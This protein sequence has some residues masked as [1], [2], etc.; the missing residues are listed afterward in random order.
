MIVLID[1]D[2]LAYRISFACKDE[3]VAVAKNT[4]N[5]A[6]TDILMCGVDNTFPN[7]Y[8]D[9]WK[10]YLTGK[11]NFRIDV[12]KTAVYKGN[13]TAPKPEHLAPLREHLVKEWGAGVYDGQE[14]DDAIAIDATHL[15]DNCIVSSVD[16]DLD[17]IPGWHYNFVKK[18]GYYISPEQSV[19][20]LYR[21]ILTGDV[22]DN[23][24]GLKGIG[25]VKAEK[26]L[27]DNNKTER[28]YYDICVEAYGGDEDRVIENARLLFLRRYTGQVWYPPEKESNEQDIPETK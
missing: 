18:Q 15:T 11:N 27:G 20:L 4:L 26:L 17:Q 7:C 16:K 8:V 13:R 24:I 25:N 23:I 6:V 28:E 9:Q 10:L 5:K 2:I 1:S 21:Q 14:A 12:A 19:Y 22:A 3:P